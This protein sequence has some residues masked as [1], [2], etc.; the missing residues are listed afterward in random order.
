MSQS[1]YRG[2]LTAAEFPLLSE[3][4]GRNVIV[5]GIDQNYSRQASSTKNKDRDI[6]IPQVYYMHNVIPTDA[7]ICSI[8]Y[9]D[10]VTSPADT[11]STFSKIYRLRD[12]AENVAYLGITKSGRN[13]ILRDTAIGWVRSTDIAP[14]A[15]RFVTTAHVNGQTYICYG[16]VGT[17]KYNFATNALDAVALTGLAA[18]TIMGICASSGYMVAWTINSVLWCSTI[19]PTDFVPSLVTGAGGES[20]QEAKA[21]ITCC[22]PQNG[23]FVVYTKLNAVSMTYTNNLQF[24]FSAKE[25]IG[26][27]GLSNP[28][29]AAFNG[30]S[31]NHCVY[32]TAGLQE[33]SMNSA[34][35]LSPQATD[36]L[37]GSEF[38]DFDE[39]SFVLSSVPLTSAMQKK[40]TV[41]ANR[42]II[43][44]YGRLSLT[45]ALYYD[46]ALARWGKLKIEHT[47][48]FEYAYPSAEVVDQP[49]KSIGFLQANGMIKAAAL[50]YDTTGSYG[51]IICGKYQMDRNRY[52]SMQEIHL[53]SVKAG[54]TMK[55]SLLTTLDGKNTIKI[56]TPTLATDIGT[57][58]KYVCRSTG[59]NHSIVMAGAFH[60]NSL[61]LK[62]SDGGAVR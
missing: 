61:E 38:E 19:S 55:L 62:F 41:V 60:A 33:I 5:G 17:Y 23:G 10:I 36:F 44:S 48:V 31:T 2:N 15:N 52:L 47:D 30:N 4:Q 12:A 53:E 43:I 16:G 35:I 27:G 40:V 28:S 50:A 45:H 26:A 3:L 29:L 24:P 51:V 9:T 49:R 42:Y 54:N 39:I 1:T 21:E 37:A 46:I 56:T 14:A 32:T 18:N 57:Y 34:S 13:Y 8:A 22:L 6:G 25:I 58:R 20:L 11:D 7:G 59:L